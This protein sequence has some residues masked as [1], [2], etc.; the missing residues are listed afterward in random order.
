MEKKDLRIL[1]ELVV[2]RSLLREAVVA[3]QELPRKLSFSHDVSDGWPVLRLK[4][5]SEDSTDSPTLKIYGNA[6]KEI[7]I[8]TSMAEES[9]IIDLNDEQ[10]AARLKDTV[11]SLVSSLLDWTVEDSTTSQSEDDDIYSKDV[12]ESSELFD[13]VEETPEEELEALPDINI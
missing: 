10:A 4:A 7:I 9:Q 5:I 12:N 2:V 1:E 13:S 3:T 6:R 11:V 8:R